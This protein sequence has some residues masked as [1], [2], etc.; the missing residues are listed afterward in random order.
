[1]F[2]VLLCPVMV[3]F[4]TSRL[5][6]PEFRPLHSEETLSHRGREMSAGS[7]FEIIVSQFMV[8]PLF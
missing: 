6:I 5:L 1:M 4:T 8:P 2:C 3:Y 7:A